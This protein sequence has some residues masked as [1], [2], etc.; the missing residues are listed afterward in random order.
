MR[1]TVRQFCLVVALLAG[2]AACSESPEAEEQ[3]GVGMSPQSSTQKA[4]PDPGWQSA[5][6]QAAAVR[7]PTVETTAPQGSPM[8]ALAAGGAVRLR[9]CTTLVG[10]E[11]EA[12]L[13][14][15][16]EAIAKAGAPSP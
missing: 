1:S 11:Y 16:E 9:P 13:A 4:L 10:E 12:C 8:A 15:N 6:T 3:D 7:P 2:V 14:E 5:N